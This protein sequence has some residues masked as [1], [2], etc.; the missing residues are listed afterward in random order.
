MASTPSTSHR[1]LV[2]LDISQH[3]DQIKTQAELYQELLALR[4]AFEHVSASAADTSGLD[5]EIAKLQLELDALKIRVSAAE[6]EIDSLQSADEAFALDITA[7]NTALEDLQGQIDLLDPAGAIEE[8][9]ELD[10]RVTALEESNTTLTDAVDVNTSK[11]GL[12]EGRMDSAEM[13]INTNSDAIGD[14]ALLIG[15]LASQITSVILPSITDIENEQIVQNN[16]IGSLSFTLGTL[17]PLVEPI[18]VAFER[19]VTEPPL[20]KA[21]D[22]NI[23][24]EDYI[25]YVDASSTIVDLTLP[26][27]ADVENKEFIVKVLVGGNNCRIHARGAEK[28][29]YVT[30]VTLTAVLQSLKVRSDGSNYWVIP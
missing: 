28:I 25:I 6:A 14:N 5:E 27:A 9:E 15:T 1:T 18:G 22:Y 26:W 16:N 8:L 23:E 17:V 7:I 29:D 12:L 19:T 30:T 3:P 24:E 21:V 2:N 4:N 11:I 10:D 13:D 20:I